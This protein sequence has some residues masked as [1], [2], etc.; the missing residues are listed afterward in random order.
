[1]STLVDAAELDEVQDSEGD[2][3]K[4]DGEDGDHGRLR[5]RRLGRW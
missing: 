2:D 4:A 5:S 3:E 1:M